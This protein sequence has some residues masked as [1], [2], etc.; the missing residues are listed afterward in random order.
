VPR[1]IRTV[2][3]RELGQTIDVAKLGPNSPLREI[4]KSRPRKPS[5]DHEHQEQVKLFEWVRE[6]EVVRPEFAYLFAV[7]NFSGRQGRRTAK[8]G[9]RLKAEG[10]RPGV[11]DCLWPLRRGRYTGFALEL[12]F[13]NNRPTA[14]Q[15][16]WL[17][18][19]HANGWRIF[20]AWSA[21]EAKRALQ[22]YWEHGE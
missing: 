16:R 13:G 8:Q 10:R 9:A 7:P 3:R 15:N 6:Q 2:S 14:A 22:R 1:M 20:V 12:K 18:H 21:D 11:P 4:L 19:L 5:A 17:A